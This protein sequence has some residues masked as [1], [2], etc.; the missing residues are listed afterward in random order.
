MTGTDR[1]QR[2]IDLSRKNHGYMLSGHR[3]RTHLT[4]QQ[5]IRDLKLICQ[6]YDYDDYEDYDDED[7]QDEDD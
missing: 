2:Y 1:S 6:D 4:H 3:G 5:K 7:D